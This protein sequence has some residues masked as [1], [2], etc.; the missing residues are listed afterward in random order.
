MMNKK[1][2]AFIIVI[3]IFIVSVVIFA[4]IYHSYSKDDID[5]DKRSFTH[6]LYTSITIQTTIGLS[7][8][9]NANVKSLQIWVMVQSVITYLIGLGIVFVLLKSFGKDDDTV[10]LR[11]E[12]QIADM[13]KMILDLHKIK[14]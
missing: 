14:Q 13:K 9:P 1:L 7:D 4:F 3:I 2:L 12:K 10:E 11:I 5:P 6:A 8:P